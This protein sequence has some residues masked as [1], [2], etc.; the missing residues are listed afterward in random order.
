MQSMKKWVWL[1]VVAGLL[2]TGTTAKADDKEAPKRDLSG[3]T[4]VTDYKV[5]PDKDELKMTAAADAPKL[6]YILAKRKSSFDLA[7]GG[8]EHL[9]FA[10]YVF[11]YSLEYKGETTDGKYYVYNEKSGDK[12]VWYFAK[13]ATAGKY[14]ILL[15]TPPTGLIDF[16]KDGEQYPRT[17]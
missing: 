13:T 7:K 9:L 12:W 11:V 14:Q 17:P 8:V 1:V 15:Y 4:K 3:E 10:K 16:D 6:V 5:D 2:A